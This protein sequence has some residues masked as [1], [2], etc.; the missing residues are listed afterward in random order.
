VYRS[1]AVQG[2][3]AW[4]VEKLAHLSKVPEEHIAEIAVRNFRKLDTDEYVH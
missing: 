1:F 2:I 3:P 4:I